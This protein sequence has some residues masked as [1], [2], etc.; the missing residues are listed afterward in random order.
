MLAK[1]SRMSKTLNQ[2][3]AR[4][5]ILTSN[6]PFH[7]CSTL[8]SQYG[9]LCT[10]RCMYLEFLALVKSYKASVAHQRLHTYHAHH[11]HRRTAPCLFARLGQTRDASSSRSTR[12]VR[13]LASCT[14]RCSSPS[15]STRG[16][17]S[18]CASQKRELRAARG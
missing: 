10:I 5:H 16:M 15:R 8:S 7:S 17:L 6:V 11:V 4:K 14:S 9:Q 12:S 13:P 3:P 1:Y 2:R 18:S